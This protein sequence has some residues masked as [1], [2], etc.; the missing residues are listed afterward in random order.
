MA[1]DGEPENA[2]SDPDRAEVHRNADEDAAREVHRSADAENNDHQRLSRDAGLY[3]YSRLAASLFG[4]ATIGIATHVYAKTAF[5]YVAT[6]L[7]MFDT[8]YALGSLGLA[9]AVFFFVGRDHKRAPAVVRQASFLLLAVSLPVIGIAMA[10]GWSLSKPDVDLIPALPW[11]A[12]ALLFAMPTQPAINQLLAI[13]QARAA[14][15]L[16]TLY[17]ALNALAIVLPA[18]AGISV[19][20]TPILLAGATSVRLLVH[21]WLM[22]N[23]FPRSQASGEGP[24]L[25]GAQLRAMLAYAFPAGMAALCGKLNPQID[26][27]VVNVLL[28]TEVFAIYTAAAWEL[29]LISMI[30]YAIGA[31]MQVRYVELY[32]RRRT[33]EL[34][35]LWFANAEKTSLVVFPAT[36]A[37]IVIAPELVELLFGAS[38][39]R[40][41]LPFQLFTAVLLHRVASYGAMLQA[42]DQTRALL[43]S[44]VLLVSTNAMLTLP[45]TYLLGY[46]GAALATLLANIPPWLWTLSRIGR[47]MGTGLGGAL[48]WATLARGLVTAGAV[49]VGIW[50]A[51]QL[52]PFHA[53]LRLVIAVLAYGVIYIPIARAVRVLSKSD[54]AYIVKWLT[55]RLH[56]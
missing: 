42:T 7:L 49:G 31:V 20:W 22:R 24:W 56:R 27:Y 36:I 17:A 51:K 39:L 50:L 13:G 43:V 29:P 38:Y 14:S 54:L 3:L 11:V 19:T 40:A 18:L 25:V 33:E 32:A 37:I 28:S 35:S 44:S 45:L 30:P 9:E 41:T 5:A 15:I 52:M 8:S 26:K 16:Q 12:L 2:A 53:A 21:L 6:I 47:A 10:V 23:V 1:T 4:L 48:P 46:P 55:F 34:R